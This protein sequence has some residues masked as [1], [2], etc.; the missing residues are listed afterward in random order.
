MPAE[1]VDLLPGR[2]ACCSVAARRTSPRAGGRRRADHRLVRAWRLSS[3]RAVSG[4]CAPA[5][6]ELRVVRC[7]NLGLTPS[8]SERSIGQGRCAGRAP[9]STAGAG[10]LALA[11]TSC[12]RSTVPCIAATS[13]STIWVDRARRRGSRAL[14]AALPLADG[15]SESAWES[16]LRL[17]H[18]TCSAQVE[19]RARAVPRRPGDFIARAD[20][21]LVGTCSIHEYDGGVHLNRDQQ[22]ADL[23]RARRLADSRWAATRYTSRDLLRQPIGILRDID[24]ALERA[25]DPSRVRAWHSMLACASLF[26]RSRCSAPAHQAW[27][28]RLIGGK[29]RDAESRSA[30]FAAD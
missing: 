15:R 27:A 10:Y 6:R 1:A 16:V 3:R 25:H 17:M 20:L 8:D 2:S 30:S 26:T 22:Q 18:V 19:P 12:R 24:R 28:V 21:W 5:R 4:A 11:W 14:R 9:C 29:R 7:S 13:A 23:T